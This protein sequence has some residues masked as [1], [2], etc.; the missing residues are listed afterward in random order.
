VLLVSHDRD[1]LNAVPDRVIHIDRGKLISYSGN[2]DSFERVRRERLKN[3]V[4]VAA[5][6][7]EQRRHMQAFIDRFRYKAS[8]R[9]RRSPASRLWPGWSRWRR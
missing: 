7:A 8:K 9:A 4:A 6:Q 1:L 2:Y 3:T 5:K